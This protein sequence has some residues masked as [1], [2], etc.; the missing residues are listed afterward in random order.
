[1]RAYVYRIDLH[2]VVC[3]PGASKP[4]ATFDVF[5]MVAVGD[6]AFTLLC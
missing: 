4:C 1:M 5:A 6:K 3:V 2:R